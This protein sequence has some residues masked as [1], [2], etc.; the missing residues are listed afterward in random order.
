MNDSYAVLS[1]LRSIHG[2]ADHLVLLFH[3]GF[4]LL[5]MFFIGQ[6]IRSATLARLDRKLS[7]LLV[8]TSNWQTYQDIHFRCLPNGRVEVRSPD[9]LQALSSVAKFERFAARRDKQAGREVD[10]VQLSGKIN[11]ATLR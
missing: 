9:G 7:A 3:L 11:A 8:D 4:L 1:Q 10:T 5:F 6:G 2:A